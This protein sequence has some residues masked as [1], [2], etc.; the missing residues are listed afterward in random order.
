MHPPY[1]LT[2][3]QFTTVVMIPRI[4]SSLRIE[5]G[6]PGPWQFSMNQT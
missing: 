5:L 1:L 4:T 6:V 3:S 2:H